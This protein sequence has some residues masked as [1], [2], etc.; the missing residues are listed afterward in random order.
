MPDY[1]ELIREICLT[2]YVHKM[3]D[4]GTYKRMVGDDD[5]ASTAIAKAVY[6]WASKQEGYNSAIRELGELKAKVYAYEQIIANSN[7]KPMLHEDS[8]KFAG[9]VADI[10]DKIKDEISIPLE[11]HGSIA[12]YD[13]GYDNAVNRVITIIE[14]YK[15][16]GK[17]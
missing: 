3:Y 12:E 10:L 15:E 9:S 13:E 7:F 11:M 6:T 8:K 4:G 5:E 14:K 17:G 16:G 1:E 2:S